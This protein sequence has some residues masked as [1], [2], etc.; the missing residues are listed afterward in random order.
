M[1]QKIAVFCNFVL[2][3]F[4]H[5]LGSPRDTTVYSTVKSA[6][7]GQ[8]DLGCEVPYNSRLM[9]VIKSG[10]FKRI[11]VGRVIE[12]V[13]GKLLPIKMSCLS[14]PQSLCLM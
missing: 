6:D 9:P 2:Q 11:M 3:G 13:F 1:R 8:L 5:S 10:Y 7:I 4:E 12:G 14:P